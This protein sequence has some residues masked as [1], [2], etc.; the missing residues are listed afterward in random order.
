MRSS[1]N[2]QLI[3]SARGGCGVAFLSPKRS[4]NDDFHRSIFYFLFPIFEKQRKREKSRRIPRASFCLVVNRKTVRDPSFGPTQ[5]T[6]RPKQPYPG[7]S[8][9][10]SRERSMLAQVERFYCFFLLP[11]FPFVVLLSGSRTAEHPNSRYFY[12]YMYIQLQEKKTDTISYL[13]SK[14]RSLPPFWSANSSTA[15]RLFFS[16]GLID[17]SE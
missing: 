15:L 5:R 11:V 3:N 9:F 14:K 12:L 4:I 16:H 7:L 10:G 8:L 2:K 6:K 13:P 17:S 1:K